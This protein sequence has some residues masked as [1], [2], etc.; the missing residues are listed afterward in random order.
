MVQFRQLWGGTQGNRGEQIVK[1]KPL[2]YYE[3]K[4]L[5]RALKMTGTPDRVRCT[6]L[7]SSRRVVEVHK[8]PFLGAPMVWVEIGTYADARKMIAEAGLLGG[9]K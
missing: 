9:T 5:L 7:A 2:T 3:K 6:T 1:E 4:H 8:L